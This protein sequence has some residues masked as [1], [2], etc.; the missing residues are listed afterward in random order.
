VK[1]II[2]PALVFSL[3]LL[4]ACDKESF[5]EKITGTWKLDR[6]FKNNLDK[7]VGFDTTYADYQITLRNDNT[8]V[9]SWF[10]QTLVDIYTLDTSGIII[11]PITTDTLFLTDTIYSFDTLRAPNE[12]TGRW[13]LINS[14]MDL[15]LR[16]DINYSRQYRIIELKTGLLKLQKGNEDYHFGR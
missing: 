6:Y 14:E 13:D 9:E 15:Q 3:L 4:T 1:K 5:L 2:F 7:T 11:D 8:F 10:T 12:V 16:D